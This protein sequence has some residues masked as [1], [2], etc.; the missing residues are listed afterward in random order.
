MNRPD[1]GMAGA[2]GGLAGWLL[3]RW[4]GRAGTERRLI[5]IERISLGPRQSLCLVKADGRSILV[6]NSADGASIYPLEGRSSRRVA[7]ARPDATRG[8]VSW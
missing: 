1:K 3:A 5:L 8:R 7:D 6:A 2:P 4:R